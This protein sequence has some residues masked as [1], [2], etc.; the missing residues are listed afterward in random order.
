MSS[1]KSV[2]LDSQGKF[3]MLKQQLTLKEEHERQIHSLETS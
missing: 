1:E 3:K 2:S